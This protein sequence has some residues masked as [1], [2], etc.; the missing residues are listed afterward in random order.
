MPLA[1]L[2]GGAAP[3]VDPDPRR[4]A[5]ARRAV[6][7]LA[8]RQRDGERRRFRLRLVPGRIG[9]AGS[10]PALFH[11]IE[12]AWNDENLREL[13]EPSTSP[14]F[15]GHVRAAAGPP[16][17][18]TNCHPFRYENWLFMHN[19]F[20]AGFA[21]MKRDLMFAVDPSLYPRILGTTDSEVLFYLALT[22]GLQRRPDRGHRRKAIRL[23]E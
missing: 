11:S 5:F 21:K 23:V 1:R 8:A 3:A 14:L 10:I 6:A 17:Q 9:A 2:L 16:I 15:F 13:T 19:G 7:E 18:Q 22:F 12:P 20:L 4:A